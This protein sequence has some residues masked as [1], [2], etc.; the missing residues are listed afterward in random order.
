LWRPPSALGKVD[1]VVVAAFGS[2]CRLLAV[3]A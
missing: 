3:T 2:R 1:I